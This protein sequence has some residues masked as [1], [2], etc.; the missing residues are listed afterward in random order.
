MAFKLLIECSKDIEK[1]NIDFSD[2]TSAVSY[3]APDP[4]P[5]RTMPTKS[6]SRPGDLLDTSE[7]YSEVSEEV[8]KLPD[9]DLSD[10]PVSVAEELQ[11]F[12]F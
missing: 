8:V 4:G 10:R 11:N 6:P 12:D 7:D 3:G 1:L 9:I 2:G 5:E